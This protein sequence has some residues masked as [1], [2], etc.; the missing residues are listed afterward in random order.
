MTKAQGPSSE[1][2]LVC[3]RCRYEVDIVVL[4]ATCPRC[5]GILDVQLAH[6]PGDFRVREDDS[7][8]WRWSEWLPRCSMQNRISLGEGRS[9]L[10]RCERLGRQIGATDF[11]VKNEGI[12]PTGSFKDRGLA[13]TLSLAR[14]YRK[15]GVVLSSSGNAG[16][17]AASYAA[18]AAIP[19]MV[20]VPDT[21][22]RS[23]LAQIIAAGVELITVKGDAS[24]CCRLARAAATKIGWV[25]ASTTFYNPYAVEAY[26]T[27]AFELVTLKPDIIVLPTSCGP[28]LVGVMKGFVRLERLGLIERVPRPV[29]AQPS[30]CAPIARAFQS[31]EP[32]RRWSQAVSVASAL[33][34]TLRDY[35]RDGDYTIEWL[36]RFD[37]IALA[38][39]DQEILAA[40]QALGSLEGIFVEPSAAVSI[41]AS[42]KLLA[43]GQLLSQDRIV[44]VATGHGLKETSANL[45]HEISEP[46]EADIRQLM[47]A[48]TSGRDQ[49]GNEDR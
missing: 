7:G 30:G 43:C 26:A 24:D 12:M 14:E 36:H 33:N 13:L 32:V 15:P 28:L 18:R 25:N 17:S 37:E 48:S 38:V 46:I 41:A 34:D 45:P 10:L 42:Q 47:L 16:A 11:W 8:I 9:P 49:V 35:E 4:P 5:D 39:S 3:T 23:K 22:S 2:H 27:L 21:T 6:V 1:D 19:A 40:A 29:A 44:A 20:L 31:G